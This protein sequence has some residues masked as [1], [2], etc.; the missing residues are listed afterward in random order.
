MIDT[1]KYKEMFVQEANEHINNLN[2][3]LLELEKNYSQKYI[4]S[5]FRSAHTLKG[6][7]AMMEYENIR[8]LCKSIEDVF[9]G[10]RSN[11][12]TLTKDLATLLFNC[13][14][15]LYRLVNDNIEI[16]ITP[17]VNSLQHVDKNKNIIT[18][19]NIVKH[20]NVSAVKDITHTEKNNTIRINLQDLDLL[21]NL[22]GE[23][24]IEKNRLA[25]IRKQDDISNIFMSLERLISDLQ[26]QTMKIR[27]VP[28]DTIFGRFNR[29]VRDLAAK[30]NKD[31]ELIINAPNIQLDISLL[32]AITEPLLH[33]IRNA[34]DHGIELPE[35][36]EKLGKPRTGKLKFS[37]HRIGDSILIEVEDDGKGINLK[38]I[39][40]KA[41]EKKIITEEEAASMSDD[42][43]IRLIGTPGLSTAEKITDVSGRGV[44]MDVV[45][46][47][48]EHVGGNVTIN[49]IEG[50]GT[51]ISI[52]VPLSI[53][54]ISGLIIYIGK[55]RYIIPALN[56][57]TT[58]RLNKNDIK[59]LHGKDVFVFDKKIIPIFDLAKRFNIECDKRYLVIINRSGSILGIPVD[60][61]EYR[62]D[63]VIKTIDNNTLTNEF[64]SATIM[65]DGNAILILDI[66]NL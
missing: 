30:L 14:D 48:V 22:V 11:N 33:I 36:R 34:I 2:T 60:F 62:D 18:D 25:M 49:T 13:F 57:I 28:I 35:E 55:E 63:I 42:D 52:R 1:N 65:A 26:Y 24:V 56:V 47:Q 59:S 44:G 43:I 23:L 16:D 64:R 53:S 29:A 54:I 15:L 10:L 38:N 21:I 37:A 31:V 4:D 19:T 41:I 3:S 7:A 17:F 50:Q 12:I 58:F 8:I 5:L 27:L 61:Y 6:M 46:N 40:A 9:D 39:L 45:F 20:E 51:K 66:N 32:D